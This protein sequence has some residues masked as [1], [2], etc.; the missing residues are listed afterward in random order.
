MP[1][2]IQEHVPGGGI[3]GGTAKLTIKITLLKQLFAYIS[4]VE[5]KTSMN[6]RCGDGGFDWLCMRAVAMV[7]DPIRAD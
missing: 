3:N 2:L 1:V 6:L 4:L 5:L 7:A